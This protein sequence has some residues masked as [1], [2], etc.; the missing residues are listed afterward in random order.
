MSAS[1]P[2]VRACRSRCSCGDRRGYEGLENRRDALGMLCGVES[3]P[4]AFLCRGGHFLRTE[5]VA[6]EREEALRERAV[7]VDGKQETGF[8]VSQ[9]VAHAAHWCGDDRLPENHCFQ[10]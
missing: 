7:V 1:G 4:S 8:A 10:Q 6:Q 3:P 5:R 9:R 2:T